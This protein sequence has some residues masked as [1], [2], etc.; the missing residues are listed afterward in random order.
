MPL[1]SCHALS[2]L[3]CFPIGLPILSYPVPS[4]THSIPLWPPYTPH[5]SLCFPHTPHAFPAP[6][7][8]VLPMPKRPPSIQSE[9]PRPLHPTP[10]PQCP[11]TPV[12]LC[13]YA[14]VPLYPCA[15]VPLRRSLPP[16]P[17][18]PTP[19]EVEVVSSERESE[20]RPALLDEDPVA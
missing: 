16:R 2:I 6:F 12:P 5:G 14:P 11:Y 4:H 18:P 17:P 1:W 19:P 13:L 3:L 9:H 8:G 7:P 15:P 10:M 20:R